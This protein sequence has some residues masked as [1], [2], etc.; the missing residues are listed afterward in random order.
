MKSY[1]DKQ[2]VSPF[3]KNESV[4]REEEG[5]RSKLPRCSYCHLPM[6][7]IDTTRI[8]NYHHYSFR[9]CNC[10]KSHVNSGGKTEIP[11]KFDEDSDNYAETKADL[12]D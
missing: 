2:M 6:L 8:Y 3:D 4:S 7:D 10:P 1:F 11:K 9:Y 5:F 12:L